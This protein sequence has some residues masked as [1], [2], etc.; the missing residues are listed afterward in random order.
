MSLGFVLFGKLINWF[1]EPPS[2]FLIFFHST[3]LKCVL[4]RLLHPN[5][6]A[7]MPISPMPR[8]RL[9]LRFSGKAFLGPPRLYQELQELQHDLSVVEEVTLLVG[10]LQGTYQVP[11]C[12]SVFHFHCACTSSQR[13]W[14]LHNIND[15]YEISGVASICHTA[16]TQP[17]SLK[18]SPLWADR[19]ILNCHVPWSLSQIIYGLVI[20]RKLTDNMRMWKNVLCRVA[21]YLTRAPRPREQTKGSQRRQRRSLSIHSL[22]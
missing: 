5:P 15:I 16:R 1:Q 17:C 11:T 12:H 22:F 10:T 2:A 7:P 9:S 18:S 19:L 13:K 8:L 21:D 14:V 20:A 4:L 3:T 6:R